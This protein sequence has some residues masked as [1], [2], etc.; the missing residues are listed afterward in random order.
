MGVILAREWAAQYPNARFVADVKST[1]LFTSDP[2]LLALGAKTDYCKTGHSYMK[3]YLNE[4]DCLAGFERSGHYVFAPPLGRGYDDG[5]AT[6][7]EVCRL[8]DR[9]PEKT[10]SN[11]FETLDKTWGN[12]P[13][14]PLCSDKVKYEIIEKIT[15]NLE[16]MAEKVEPFAGRRI[17]S[18]SKINGIR[19]QF[20]D[21]AWVLIRASSNMPNLVV[22]CESPNSSN[23]MTSILGFVKNLLSTYP[24]IDISAF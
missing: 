9:Y 13:I 8:L 6:A 16:K 23:E 5:I 24:E 14:L 15:D 4:H 21:G 18:I 17:E 22:I 11:F 10:L 20:Q 12:I 2:Q 3:R 1:S 19:V 7:L